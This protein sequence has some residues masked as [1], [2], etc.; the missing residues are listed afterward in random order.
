MRADHRHRVGVAAEAAEEVRH[1]LV[2]HGVVGDA[3]L[4]VLELGGGRQLAVEQQVGDLEEVR[5]LGQ[6]LDRVAAVEQLALVAVDVGDG[7]LAGAGRGI[8]GVE[9]EDAAFGVEAADVDDV[10]ADGALVDRQLEVLS[11]MASLAVRWAWLVMRHPLWSPVGAVGPG[12]PRRSVPLECRCQASLGT[13]PAQSSRRARVS[14]RPSIRI[15][16]KTP[17]ETVRPESATRSG[18]A[19]LPSPIPS[20][21]AKSRT[22]ASRSSA[23][24]LAFRRR[25]VNF[26]SI[27][28]GMPASAL[29]P[30][31]SGDEGALD[32]G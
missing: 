13:L 5:L 18:W 30:A 26:P 3:A 27:P 10:G 6:L 17:K 31:A 22:A 23:V 1:L 9:G 11:S 14:S 12:S 29:A 4:E 25:E 32:R 16:S 20:A 15:M 2:Q 19:T 24:Q 7:A 8:A 28:S 21:A